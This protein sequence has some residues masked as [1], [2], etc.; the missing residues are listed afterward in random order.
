MPCFAN[1]NAALQV[2]DDTAEVFEQR[3]LLVVDHSDELVM[4]GLTPAAPAG[5]Q[6]RKL[7]QLTTA[8]LPA[9]ALDA[10]DAA[11][12]PAK[13]IAGVVETVASGA[14]DCGA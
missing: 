14:A 4:V 11:R 12:L 6:R 13:V 8:E 3:G 1:F 9:Q 5:W 7:P 10:T 2:A